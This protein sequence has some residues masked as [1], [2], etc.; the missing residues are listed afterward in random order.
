MFIIVCHLLPFYQPLI[1]PYEELWYFSKYNCHIQLMFICSWKNHASQDNLMSSQCF[2][3]FSPETKASNNFMF[4]PNQFTCESYKS[5]HNE[6]I[7]PKS[8]KCD[9]IAINRQKRILNKCQSIEFN[10]YF[11]LQ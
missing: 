8:S 9:T 10:T 3:L 4:N 6:P 1:F 11:C 7:K 2:A 5:Y